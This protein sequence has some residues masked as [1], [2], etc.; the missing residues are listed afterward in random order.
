MNSVPR[1]LALAALV[2]G[3]ADWLFYGHSIGISLALFVVILLGCTALAN[4]NIT[5]WRAGLLVTG[6][7]VAALAP[8][9]ESLNAASVICCVV[10]SALV[11]AMIVAPL[12]TS[13][14]DLLW[15]ARCFLVTGPFRLLPDLSGT[16]HWTVAGGRLVVW[17]MPIVLGGVFL[18]LFASANP[19]IEQW[20]GS[21]DIGRG[22]SL[23]SLSRVIF[24][25]A[26]LSAIWPFIHVRLA[27]TE[28]LPVIQPQ[29]P[30]ADGEPVD[31]VDWLSNE[32]FGTAAI[33]RSLVLF[34]LLFLVQTV[35]DAVYLWGGVSLPEGMTY[36]AYAHR[37]AY[38][39]I[40][41]ALLAA[42]F[43]LSVTNAE[44]ASKQTRM[45][46]ILIVLWAAQNLMLVLSSILRLDLYVE[47]YSLTYLRVAAFIW[48]LLVAFGLVLIVAR[49]LLRRSNGWLIRMNAMVLAS[50]LYVCLFVNFPAMVASYNVADSRE[51]GGKGPSLDIDYLVSLGPQA[52]PA[53]DRFIRD[54]RRS[55]PQV[56]AGYRYALAGRHRAE[57]DSWRGW[58]FRGWRLQRYL[59]QEAVAVALR[60]SQNSGSPAEDIR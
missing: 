29:E 38:P 16:G 53:F 34:N 26:A 19:M 52:I 8:S 42:G 46:R 54:Q 22:V 39:L 2:T 33:F 48:M 49:L 35:L 36:A 37:G 55:H 41:T 21:I 24:W 3:A 7:L 18:A 9:V 59:D 6:G 43:I 45:V 13:L 25:F 57:L 50:V 17:V 56:F 1:Q 27:R 47:V 28:R 15:A 58:S 23:I 30:S 40:V 44:R 32:L 12:Q 51:M 10:G 20:L 11:A 60:Q 4:A 5:S 31:D 14:R